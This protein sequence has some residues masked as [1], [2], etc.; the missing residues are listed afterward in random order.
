MGILTG[1]TVLDLS[2]IAAG[3]SCTQMLADMGATVWKI[4]RPGAGDDTRRIRPFLKDDQGRDTLDS[5]F[6]LALNRGKQSITIDIA[7]PDGAALV[8]D[9]AA[10]ADIFV[11]NYKAGGLSKYGLDYAG[12]SA[13][14]PGIVYCSI[15]GFGQTG[16]HAARPAYDSIM[17]ATAG[18]MSMCGEP[19]GPPMRTAINMV[20]LT[21]GYVACVSILAALLHKRGTG[22]GQ[23]IDTAMLDAAVALNA[24]H[25]VTWLTLGEIPKRAGN[26]AP[27][28]FPSGV[29]PTRDDD[30]IVVTANDGQYGALCRV[31]GRPDLIDD[32]RYV[33]NTVRRQNRADLRAELIK[34]LVEKPAAEWAELLEAAGVA[35][36]P[37]NA[38]DG[39][40]RDPQVIHRQLALTMAHASGRDVTVA[41]S[42]LNF[43]ATPVE[44]RAPPLLGA[45][46]EAV[47]TSV[48]GCTAER[49]ASLRAAKVI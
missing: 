17:Q 27:N 13:I 5:A 1:V 9:L 37:I 49:I 33:T 16:P 7:H 44:H 45:Q 47:L 24:Q 35:S 15:T 32:P 22:Q 2:R 14:N 26:G 4:E 34:S 19:D 36:A 23:S 8:R 20:D 11:E 31:I 18:L 30:M 42:P 28:T 41:R 3:P 43:S 39:V 21:T 29:F 25:A 46:T 38:M 6:F 12:I 48:L 10:K 40:F